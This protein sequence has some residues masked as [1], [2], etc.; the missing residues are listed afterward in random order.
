LIDSVILRWSNH[1]ILI[2]YIFENQSFNFDIKLK[3]ILADILK[4]KQ[5]NKLTN[6][7][8]W[9]KIIS[10]LNELEEDNYPIFHGNILV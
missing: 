1:D 8:L 4:R 3:N 9:S 5:I 7:T 10:T 6:E 2:N